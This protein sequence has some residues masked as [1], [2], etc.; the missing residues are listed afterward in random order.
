[1][2]RNAFSVAVAFGLPVFNNTTAAVTDDD[3]QNALLDI[4]EQTQNIKARADAEGRAMNDDEHAEVDKLDAQFNATE[5][6]ILR[7]KKITD[8]AAKLAAPAKPKSVV[9]DQPANGDPPRRPAPR[10]EPVTGPKGMWGFRSHAE[11]YSSVLKS[12]QK[13]SAIDPR[14]IANAP[15][16]YGQEGVG[17]DGGF[18]VPPDIRSAIVQKVLG[19]DSLLALTDQQTSSSNSIS[20]PAD[21]TTPW[22]TSGGITCAWESEAGQKGQS[23]PSLTEKT[24]KLNKLVALV[25][26]TDE[27]LEDAPALAG[28]VGR[29]ASEKIGYKVNDAIINGTGAGQPKGILTSA[30]TI[31]V[32][33]ESGQA[34][35]TVVFGNIVKMFT[36]LTPTARRNSRWLINPDVEQQL[37][38]MS[39]PGS[40]TAVPVYLPP[41]GLSA[42]PYGTLM[43]RPVIPTEACQALGTAGDIIHADLSAYLSVLKG[44]LR[45]DVSM[46]LY[47]DYDVTA[48]RFVLRVGGQPWWDSTI[49]PANGSTT[50][51]FF[52]TLA[53]RA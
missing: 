19:E 23:K 26:V 27:L 48:F 34:A 11:F 42:S 22:Q 20:F 14:L 25:P 51:G 50:R 16:T 43:G 38:S 31:S 33:A 36:R 35:A 45:S 46:H 40:G 10:I 4:F 37:M 32:T 28:Y 49:S 24:V 41:G 13:G 29:K 53:T 8:M 47:F 17:A 1:M 52:A 39:F 12:S 5:A 3:L 2:N 44:G 7:R 15:T 6:E 30:G 21:E 9:D 18:A